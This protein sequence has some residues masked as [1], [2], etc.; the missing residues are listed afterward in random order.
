MVILCEAV[1]GARKTTKPSVEFNHTERSRKFHSHGSFVKKVV[2]KN[3]MASHLS[4][5][6]RK[7]SFYLCKNYHALAGHYWPI[8]CCLYEESYLS[9]TSLAGLSQLTQVAT[10]VDMRLVKNL[11]CAFLEQ[12]KSNQ[13]IL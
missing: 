2:T 8:S 10:L 13:F 7:S 12:R 4:E 6:M 1:Y 9:E 3:Q 11:K 5:A